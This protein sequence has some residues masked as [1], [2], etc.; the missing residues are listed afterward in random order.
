M[1]LTGGQ[2]DAGDP[3]AQLAGVVGRISTDSGVKVHEDWLGRPAQESV[4]NIGAVS[5]ALFSGTTVTAMVPDWPAV[6]VS[7]SDD[8]AT[9]ARV[10]L[11]FGVELAC[12]LTLLVAEVEPR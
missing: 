2:A 5:D 11:K 1:E 3:E 6:T 4:M 10:K 12:P 9:A 7:G 8:G